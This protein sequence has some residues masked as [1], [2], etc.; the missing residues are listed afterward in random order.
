MT[1]YTDDSRTNM[2]KINVLRVVWIV[3]E[4]LFLSFQVFLLPVSFISV[5]FHLLI[6]SFFSVI[7]CFFR[8]HFTFHSH[9]STLYL[10]ER[11]SIEGCQSTKYIALTDSAETFEKN[12]YMKSIDWWCGDT[13]VLMITVMRSLTH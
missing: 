13:D 7:S 11:R 6:S 4:P 12:K 9:L 10:L 5:S 1:W 3:R 8:V 2:G